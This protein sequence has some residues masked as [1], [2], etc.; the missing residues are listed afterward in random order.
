MGL[1]AQY[2]FN[3]IRCAGGNIIASA[4][5]KLYSFSAS[6]GRKLCTWPDNMIGIAG[7]AQENGSA[8]R[9]EEP[10]EKR[11]KL[12][13]TKDEEDDHAEKQAT[14]KDKASTTA[15]SSIPIIVPTPN[16]RHVVAVTAED[17]HIRVFEIGT[18][19]LLT[20]LSAR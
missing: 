9:S 14:G 2:P 1:K 3:C 6:D 20:Q 10:P 7:E 5:P 18:E 12:S 8:E 17:K 4:G 19:G 15:W 11:R 13:P 16:G